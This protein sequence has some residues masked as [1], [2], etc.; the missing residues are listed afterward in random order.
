MISAMFLVGTLSVSA[1]TYY[2]KYLYQIDPQTGM[3]N[4]PGNG[5]TGV[6]ITF[7]NGKS[8]CYESDKNGIL[9]RPPNTFGGDDRILVYNYAGLQNGMYI[10]V[11]TKIEFGYGLSVGGSSTR[12]FSQDYSRMNLH[13]GGY[14]SIPPGINVYERSTPP[15]E[16][17]IP[18]KMY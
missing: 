10:F 6:Y 17:T 4:N 13:F 15:E 16:Q 8:A 7:T 18:Q 9:K 2:Y 3:K 1:Q 14:F 11:Q 12:T 5:S